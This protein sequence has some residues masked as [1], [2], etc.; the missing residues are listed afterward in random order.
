MSRARVADIKCVKRVCYAILNPSF[1]IGAALC[2]SGLT[3]RHSNWGND[4]FRLVY[5]LIADHLVILG[6]ERTDNLLIH[7]DLSTLIGRN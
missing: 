2:A 3:V 4:Y 6:A 7:R 1:A 5:I